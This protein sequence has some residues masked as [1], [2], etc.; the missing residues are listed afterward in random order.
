MELASDDLYVTSLDR[1]S[2]GIA[3]GS[4]NFILNKPNQAGT[5]SETIAAIK[6][7][8]ESWLDSHS[9]PPLR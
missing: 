7:A 8:R 6:M 3:E 1:L 9:R 2:R 5:I 4:A